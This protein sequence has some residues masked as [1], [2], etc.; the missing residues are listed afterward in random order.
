MDRILLFHLSDLHFGSAVQGTLRATRG[1]QTGLNGHSLAIAENLPVAINR[2]LRRDFK[3]TDNDTIEYLVDG[4]LTRTGSDHDFYLVRTYLYSELQWTINGYGTTVYSLGLKL[5]PNE[6]HTVA[7]NHDHWKGQSSVHPFNRP[8]AYNDDVYLKGFFDRTVTKAGDPSPR[9]SI[10]SPN[11]KIVLDLFR[12]DS[13]EGL[14]H[15][16]TNFWAKGLLS[17]RQLDGVVT[18]GAIVE[19]GLLQ[20]MHDAAAEARYDDQHAIPHV[21]AI[22]CHH[23]FKNKHGR[24]GAKPLDS[25]S[26]IRLIDRIRR[27]PAEFKI[28]AVLTGHT[29]YPARRPVFDMQTKPKVWEVRC[30]S[31][32]QMEPQPAAQ[33]FLVHVLTLSWNNSPMWHTWTYSWNGTSFV[34]SPVAKNLD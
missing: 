5:D 10:R 6:V 32:I 22:A 13:N 16:G 4:D 7:G 8:P 20:Q 1:F 12:L 30:S 18:N 34:R 29:H 24:T 33:S 19:N 28:R 23:G 25:N 26:V 9:R 17:D 14:N 11:N 2:A 21:A 27:F 31:T 3:A 15:S